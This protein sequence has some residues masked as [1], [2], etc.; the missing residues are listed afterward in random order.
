MKITFL[1][2]PSLDGQP[3]ADRLA[4]C[5]RSLYSLPNCF[6]LSAAAVIERRGFNVLYVN[7]PINNLGKQ[8]FE[9]YS[10]ADNSHVYAIY[11]VNLTK[12]TDRI[13]LSVIKK[14][15]PH[16]HIIFYGP[17][18]TYA[19][20]DY[21]IYDKTYVVRGEP[22]KTIEELV[23]VI[24]V[25]ACVKEVLGITSNINGMVIENGYREL[26][27]NL[28]ELP[29]Q[30]IHLIENDKMKYGSPKFGTRPV[31]VMTTSRNCPHQCTY[32]VPS[33]HSFAR[34][35]EYRRLFGKKPPVRKMSPERILREIKH[36]A[37][38]DYKSIAFLDDLFV[39]G[40]QRT[41]D[42]CAGL[43]EYS[44]K[45]GC[46]TRA[47]TIDDEIAKAMYESGCLYVGLGIESFDKKILEDIRK[48]MDVECIEPAIE[49]LKKHGIKV[50]L[51]VLLG[52]SQ[53][54]SKNTISYSMNKVKELDV[55][56]V[57][58]NIANPFPGTEFYDIAKKKGWFING[59]YYP[60]DVQKEAIVNLPL[61]SGKDLI[62]AV[63]KGNLSFFLNIKFIKKNIRNYA[64]I[65]DFLSALKSLL[66]KLK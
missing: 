16:A 26:I 55:D 34:E 22:E 17:S 41:L 52:A 35:L 28:D 23:C 8:A 7:F 13:A 64:T 2:P 11:G 24:S 46:S 44:V 66:R 40:K 3:V 21:L 63:K 57:M 6:E 56:Q 32:C 47:D 36:L 1:V 39:M 25:K 33:S 18:P 29:F 48:D 45:W 27:E 30:A 4:G 19:P 43:R 62:R 5:A 42:I 53:Y 49:I 60:S 9:K 59:D 14:N 10:K 65:R 51:N 61:I 58:Y 38:N 37:D 31:A 54:E 15:N 50:K 20:N 12:E